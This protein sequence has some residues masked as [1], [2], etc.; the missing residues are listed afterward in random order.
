MCVFSPDG[1]VPLRSIRGSTKH[2]YSSTGKGDDV[3]DNFA[4]DYE[5]K[6]NEELFILVMSFTISIIIHFLRKDA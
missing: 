5:F 6:V 1:A 2:F 3:D 4:R